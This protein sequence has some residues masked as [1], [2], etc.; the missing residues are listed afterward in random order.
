MFKNAS[1]RAAGADSVSYHVAEFDRGD[2]RLSVSSSMLREFARCP[3]RWRK[4]YV[5][6]SSPAMAFGNL[7]DCLLL[8]P[9]LFDS[10]YV[11][12]PD[13]YSTTAMK[14]PVCGSVSDSK[15]CRKC[16]TPRV[17]LAVD[18]PWNGNAS[19]CQA[20]LASVDGKEI[21]APGLMADA[22]AAVASVKADDAL[23]AFVECSLAQVWVEGEWHDDETGLVI[24]VRALLDAVPEKDSIYGKSLG[25]LKTCTSAALEPFS[26][27]VYK[28][29]YHAQAAFH[30]DLYCEATGEERLNWCWLLVES[31]APW[32]TGRRL[33]A[34]AFLEI[35]RSDYRK[36]L[37]LYCKC[38]SMN[39]W[40]DYDR[41]DITDAQGWTVV[42]P[43]PWMESAGAFAP[44]FE[45]NEETPV[46][47]GEEM[48]VIP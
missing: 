37:A 30:M 47:A 10:R 14:C 34:Q 42:N 36:A 12:R 20:W 7:V 28:L 43:D 13:T 1:I 33:C 27:H 41:T 32:Q 3:A 44:Q 25:D 29:G 6:P 4:G 15:E 17:L 46:E 19:E 16:K 5:G 48:D 24:P 8:T 23:A 21:V 9:Q 40:P 35:G 31:Y 26:R 2:K 18:K 38:L 22:R 39:Q 45:V 11:V